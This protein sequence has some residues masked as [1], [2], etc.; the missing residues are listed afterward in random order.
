MTDAR[1]ILWFTWFV[2]SNWLRNLAM[3]SA[4][5]FLKGTYSMRKT[6]VAL[7]HVPLRRRCFPRAP[8]TSGRAGRSSQPRSATQFHARVGFV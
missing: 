3:L 5:R 6:L 1:I 7:S 2:F 4:Q 8:E